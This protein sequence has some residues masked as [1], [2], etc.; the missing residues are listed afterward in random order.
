MVGE[1]G[2]EAES[3]RQTRETWHHK[4]RP[5]AGPGATSQTIVEYFRGCLRTLATGSGEQTNW[6]EVVAEH[7]ATSTVEGPGGTAAQPVGAAAH[8][9]EHFNGRPISW[10]GVAITCV[11]FI[12]GGVAFFPH[13]TWWLFW[14]GA[15]VAVVGLL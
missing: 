8:A 13:P 3:T 14:V 9:D 2:R 6:E 5:K 11:G 15:G 12:I 7:A 4:Q 1:S 10:V